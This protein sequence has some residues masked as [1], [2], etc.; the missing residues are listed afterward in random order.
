[1]TDIIKIKKWIDEAD[2]IIIGAGSGLSEE[3]GI[4]Y[5]GEKFDRDFIDYIRKYGFKDLHSALF[6]PYASEEERWACL[7]KYIYFT[8]Y[9]NKHTELYEKLFKIFKD[10]NYFIITTNADGQF[11]NNGFNPKKVFEVQG[12]YSKLQCSTPCNN[13]LYYNEDI[14]KDMLNNINNDLEIPKDLIPKCPVCGKRMSI[15]IRIDNKFVE[16]DN[17]NKMNEDYAKF[18]KKNQKKNV[19]LIEFGVGFNTPAII[20][21]PFEWMTYDN[22][23]FKLIRFNELYP[24][25]S[26]ELRDRSI[27]VSDDISE[28]IDLISRL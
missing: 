28:V 26:D 12:N 10:K 25:I 27:S 5:S 20:R 2:A 24:E 4:K 15:N 22:E 16:D 1:M 7:A 19:L 11:I 18:I 6:F 8:Y 13:K 9:E 17:W 3:A 14:V 23:N 21:N